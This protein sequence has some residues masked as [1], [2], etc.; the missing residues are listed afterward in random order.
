MSRYSLLR[1]LVFTLPPE[2][3][4]RVAIH[5]LQR[6]LVPQARL[7]DARLEVTLAGLTL[8]NPVGLAAGFDKNAEAFAGAFRAGFGWVEIGTVTPKPQGGNPRPRVF[9]LVEEAAVINRLG[10]NNDGVD[11]VAARLARRRLAGGI[12]GGNIGK[13]KESAD[14]S[15]DYVTAARALY[16]LVDYLTVN[17][18]SPN[19]PGLR[20]L[21]AATALERL[22][23]ALYA[24]RSQFTLSGAARK[25]IFV[26]L[27]P[28]N[29]AATMREIANLARAMNF[30]G[31]IIS[32]TTIARDHIHQHRLAAEAGGLSGRPL[33]AHSTEMLRQLYRLTEG[34]IPLIG[35]GG[36]ASAA[37]AYEKIRAGASAVQL[38]TALIYQG[39]GLVERI[40]RGIIAQ[41][42]REGVSS[43]AALVGKDV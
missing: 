7:H 39:F 9:R 38:Y 13:N 8:P 37:D 23:T 32:N 22:M 17:I 4:H 35:V 31:L 42:E 6:G 2:W 41:M 12:L 26:K 10:F 1:P 19:T 20:D 43:L 14:A 3:A 29:D 24:L 27:S 28:D 5:A 40:N 33:F 18:S 36:I 25:P 16:P 21:Q 34:K 15:A 11:M 30:D